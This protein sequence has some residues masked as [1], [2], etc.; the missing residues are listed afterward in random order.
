VGEVA[1]KA[2]SSANFSLR[3]ACAFLAPGQ[4]ASVKCREPDAVFEGVAYHY[5][6]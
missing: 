5:R 3:N 1:A 2:L 6:P 4:Y